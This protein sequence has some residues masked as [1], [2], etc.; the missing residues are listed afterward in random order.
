MPWFNSLLISIV[1]L[2]SQSTFAQNDNKFIKI[3]STILNKSC[4]LGGCHDG[5][6][7][8]NYTTIMSSYNTLVYHPITKN[9]RE[10]EFKYR[11]V[12]LDHTN[13]VLFERI[14]NCCFVD[15]DDR[16]PFYD[17][18]GLKDS[19]IKLIKDWI[20]EGA[21][22]IYGNKPQKIT[23]LPNPISIQVF[24]KQ[25][26]ERQPRPI[27]EYVKNSYDE[28]IGLNLKIDQFY[29][30]EISIDTSQNNFIEKTMLSIVTS[31][32]TAIALF[33]MEYD[34]VHQVLKAEINTFNLEKNRLYTFQLSNPLMNGFIYPSNSTPPYSR[35]PWSFYLQQL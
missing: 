3:Y 25:H 7:E 9:N 15:R 5:S 17:Q 20:N 26:G 8:P 10:G 21:L 31:K 14:T 27:E 12:P 18:E 30:I 4:A 6:F 22:D 11:V 24:K 19:Q 2:F 29:T 33:P 35:V 13:S 1:L 16:M 28:P 32:H 34:I 23:A